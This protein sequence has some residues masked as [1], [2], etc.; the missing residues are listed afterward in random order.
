MLQAKLSELIWTVHPRASFLH[1]KI[2]QPRIPR[3][4]TSLLLHPRPRRPRASLPRSLLPASSQERL[5]AAAAP[6]RPRRS[7]RGRPPRSLLLLPAAAATP[8]PSSFFPTA[9]P[10]CRRY[11]ASS[12]ETRPDRASPTRIRHRSRL[13]SLLHRRPPPPIAAPPPHPPVPGGLLVRSRCHK[14]FRINQRP[15]GASFPPAQSPRHVLVILPS[16]G[17]LPRL[18]WPRQLR[19]RVCPYQ[20]APMLPGR[21]SSLDAGPLLCRLD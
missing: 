12:P 11:A 17:S 8:R 19:G 5:P 4:K 2:S 6:P 9:T 15:G 7:H 10:R 16:T 14:F 18:L 3:A 13:R 20:A 21:R 1:P